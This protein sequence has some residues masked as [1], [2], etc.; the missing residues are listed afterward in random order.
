[1]PNEMICEMINSSITRKLESREELS[2]FQYIKKQI[3]NI[4]DLKNEPNSIEYY[5]NKKQQYLI[6]IFKEIKES[7]QDIIFDTE[8]YYMSFS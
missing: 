6:K 3:N 5:E 1:M 7:F 2:M 4:V 8:N